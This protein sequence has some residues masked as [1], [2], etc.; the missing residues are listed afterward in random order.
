MVPLPCVCR[1]GFL[2]VVHHLQSRNNDVAMFFL[3]RPSLRSAKPGNLIALHRLSAGNMQSAQ[4][5]SGS[6]T[7]T[8]EIPR[9]RFS[10]RDKWRMPG[11]QLLVS[12]LWPW[13]P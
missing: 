3:L 9:H 4:V 12:V 10:R 1:Q 6:V 8:G 13:Q 5:T 11:L 7:L 2:A